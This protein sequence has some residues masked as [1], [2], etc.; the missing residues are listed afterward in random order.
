[1]K[2]S[3]LR[4]YG[5][6]EFDD[7]DLDQMFESHLNEIYGDVDICGSTFQAGWALKEL[8]PT[9]FR[10]GQGDWLDM[11]VGIVEIDG[12]YWDAMEVEEYEE[13]LEEQEEL[14]ELALFEEDE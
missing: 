14:E 13:W 7:H 4:D 6:T 8:S 9:D 5:V 3:D 2:A 10:C 11:D 12:C 1:M